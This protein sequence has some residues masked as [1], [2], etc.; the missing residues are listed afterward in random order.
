[1]N[2]EQAIHEAMEYIRNAGVLGG[3]GALLIGVA[4]VALI[5]LY[6]GQRE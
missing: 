4:A 2:P 3:A 1:M 6:L 5:L